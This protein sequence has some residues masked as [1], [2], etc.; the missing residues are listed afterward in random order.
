MKIDSIIKTDIES[1]IKESLSW[2]DLKG[3]FFLITGA[4]SYIAF[5]I[6]LVLLEI[7]DRNDFGIKVVALCRNKKKSEEYFGELINRD[8]FKLLIQDVKE[9]ISYDVKADYIIHAASPANPFSLEK[10]DAIFNIVDSNINGL[11]NVLKLAEEWNSKVLFF[12]SSTV[13]GSPSPKG[14]ADENYRCLIDFTNPKNNYRLAKMMCEQIIVSYNPVDARIIRP[15]IV[16]GPGLVYSQRKHTSDFLKNVINKE[17]IELKSEGKAVRNFCYIADAVAGFFYVLLAGH[18]NE[19]YN[20]C[21]R[22]GTISVKELA[23]RYAKISELE[24]VVNKEQYENVNF[25]KTSDEYITCK[26]N[27]LEALGWR[28]K[29]SVDEGVKRTITWGENNYSYFMEN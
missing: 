17:R 6:I 23:K 28:E 15:T 10:K 7:N 25:L 20:I 11:I 4:R 22:T 19:T 5:Y 3:K 1:I 8:D 26:C 14:G 12:S 13:Y 18:K 24:I 21:S 9:P 16:Y 2:A 27:K 29:V